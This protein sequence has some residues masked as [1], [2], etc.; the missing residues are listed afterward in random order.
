MILMAD[1][2]LRGVE[3]ARGKFNLKGTI[4]YRDKMGLQV[5]MQVGNVD[6]IFLLRQ[7]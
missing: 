2:L 7:S 3:K 1:E 4:A 5:R 6:L